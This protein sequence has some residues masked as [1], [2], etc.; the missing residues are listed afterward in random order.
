MDT[1]KKKPAH[2]A[3]NLE[4]ASVLGRRALN[5][6]LLERQFLLRR[7]NLP[8]LEAI[9]HLVGLQAQAPNPP[10]YALWTR[11][12]EFRQEELSQLIEER[13]AVRIAMMRSTIYLVSARDCLEMRPWIQGVHDRAFTGTYG[14]SLAGLDAQALAAAGRALVEAKPKTFSEIGKRLS[15]EWP[16][17]DPDALAAAIRT[18]VPLVQVPPRGLWGQSGQSLHTSS[19]LWLGSCLSSE[20]KPEIMIQ[21]Y[22]SAFG[23]ASVKDMQAWSGQTRLREVFE[24]LRPDLICFRDEQGNELFDLPDAPRPDPASA[25]QPRFLGEYDNILL[26]H[27]DRTR[28]IDDTYR[29]RVFTKNGIIR[30]VILV[31][32]FVSGIWNLKRGSG[33]AT[34][35]IEPFRSLTSQEQDELAVEG[36]K[37]LKFA[38]ADDLTPDIQFLT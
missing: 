30:S 27:A 31:D 35:T 36:A 29:N 21:R 9:E 16:D 13:K 18:M 25:A 6:A 32:G 15:E 11:L 2:T 3:A 23:P 10:Y 17:R 19:E 12:E 22:L 14:K 1:G 26:S 7:V 24:K 8:A 33:T 20:P 5:R 38:A 37:L 28:I 34:L 4:T